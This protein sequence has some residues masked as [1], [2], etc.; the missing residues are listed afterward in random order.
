MTTKSTPTK[1]RIPLPVNPEV[2]VVWS[3]SSVSAWGEKGSLLPPTHNVG[4]T[5]EPSVNRL[6]HLV[7][8][9]NKRQADG[10]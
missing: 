7:D 2:D 4:S 6:R 5:W 8:K 1:P 3:G 9:I 10:G